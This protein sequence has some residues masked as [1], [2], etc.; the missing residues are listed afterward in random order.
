MEIQTFGI[1]ISEHSIN[2]AEDFGKKGNADLN[3]KLGETTQDLKFSVEAV[4][5]VGCCGQSPVITIGDDI[6]GYM[7]QTMVADIIKE[8]KQ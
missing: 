7:K 6:Y 5:C 1:D 2:A 4:N 8:F 3:I